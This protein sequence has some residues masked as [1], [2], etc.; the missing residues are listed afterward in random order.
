MLC[1]V[2]S[3]CGQSDLIKSKF[4][5]ETCL[6]FL[7]G[8]GVGCGEN[9]FLE[10]SGTRVVKFTGQ[11]S[12]QTNGERHCGPKKVLWKPILRLFHLPCAVNKHALITQNCV[13]PRLC[14]LIT[15]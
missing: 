11:N 7:E 13:Q 9:N 6:N 10:I 8:A 14:F 3:S 4:C 2:V 1:T 15:S 12:K 5:G